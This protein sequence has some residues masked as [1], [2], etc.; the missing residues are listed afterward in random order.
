MKNKYKYLLTS[1]VL[2]VFYTSCKKEDNYPVVLNLAEIDRYT[3]KAYTLKD[4]IIPNNYRYNDVADS[5]FFYSTLNRR[6]I[7]RNHNSAFLSLGSERDGYLNLNATISYINDSIIFRIDDTIDNYHFSEELHGVGDEYGIVLSGTSYVKRY[8]YGLDGFII[9]KYF[10][11]E[12][13]R[14]ELRTNDTLVLF[15]FKLKYQ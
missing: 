1:L 8:P 15:N 6:I 9:Y 4:S 12:K 14:N 7:F 3:I 11:L 2:I 10:N 13:I 5:L